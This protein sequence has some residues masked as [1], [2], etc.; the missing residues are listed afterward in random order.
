[1]NTS[2]IKNLSKTKILCTLGPATNSAA[3]IKDLIL[4]GMEGVRLNFSHAN[5]EEFGNLFNEIDKA[6]VDEKTPLAILM[7]L[8]GPKIRIGEL[9]KSEI[10]I[11]AGD[12]IEITTEEISGT[13][14]I[15]STS[16]KELPDDA[17]VNDQILIDDGLIRL[18]IK[19]KKKNSVVCTI[20]TGGTLRPRKGM[21]LPGMTLSTPSVTKKDFEDLEFALKHRIDY[22]ALS[23][24]RSAKDIIE[25]KE[26]L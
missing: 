21:N 4:A 8:Q 12:E 25:I 26:W 6:C 13:S 14:K 24:V 3:I 11:T 7:D 17:Q 10:E 1:M 23:F 9:T 18:R 16:Y 20:E 15:I 22:I 2:T 5:Y 19:D